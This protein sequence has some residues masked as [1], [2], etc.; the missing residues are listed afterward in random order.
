[1]NHLHRRA[2]AGAAL[3]A[4]AALV[5]SGCSGT[6]DSAAP[7]TPESAAGR[8]ALTYD[9]GL[10][11]LDAET[12]ETEADIS[13]AGF[14]RLNPAGDDR[15]VLVS[16]EAGFRVLDTAEPE[17]TDL[18][19]DAPTPGHVVRHHGRTVLFSD[20]TGA[21]TIFDT[22]D[23]AAAVAE[24][25]L[26]ET[27]VVEAPAA[28]HG[29]SIELAD[30]TLLTTIGDSEGRTGVRALDASRTE[31]GRSEDC[32]AVHGEGTAEDEVTVFGCSDGVLVYDD[33]AFTK[34]TAPDAY[35]R[36]GNQYV[37][38]TSPITVGDY[39][40]DPDAE[41]VELS[42]IVLT[43]TVAKESTVHEL[44]F[45]YTW[46]GIARTADDGALILGTDGALHALDVS[47]GEITESFPVIEAWSG[48]I[49]WQEA[50]PALTVAGDVAYV[51]EPAASA[52][53][54]VD[55]ATGEVLASATLPGA[56][57]ELAVVAG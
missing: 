32:P 16:T 57:I 48:P 18:V 2:L 43:D 40:S 56:P 26:P 50:H 8:V 44:D 35:G 3:T 15:H 1:M 34:V 6:G 31:T 12:L 39:N 20:G 54:A 17:L 38:E 51:T 46:R 14:T 13:L 29:V 41:G 42:Q 30:G 19:F 5:L 47:T 27:E 10:L 7:S 28:H 9:G 23:L 21:T 22:S 49:E 11:V 36:T 53:H 37:S 45:G 52:V 25:E 55:V 4:S 33:G 24:G